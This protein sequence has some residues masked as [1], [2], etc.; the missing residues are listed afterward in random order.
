MDPVVTGSLIS[1]GSSV[2]GGLFGSKSAKR[3]N[4]RNEALQR[5]FAQHGIQWKVEDAKRAGIH[6]VA[7]LGAQGASYSPSTVVDPMGDALAQ[8]GQSIGSGVS[9][10]RVSPVEQASIR[11]ADAETDYYK[12]LT[13][14]S[15][16]ARIGQNQNHATPSVQTMP[17]AEPAASAL[18]LP[19]GK[20]VPLGPHSDAE[21]YETRYGDVAQE[22]GGLVTLGGDLVGLIPE[23]IFDEI[24]QGQ[25]D[26]AAD[27]RQRGWRKANRY[28]KATPKPYVAGVQYNSAARRRARRYEP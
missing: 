6:P 15:I 7:A 10:T 26:H 25:I 19:G 9:R 14:A 21:A 17:V 1:A 23:S 3:Q 13:R 27:I 8:A 12:E 24:V 22:V 11:K 2:L 16:Q 5:E 28:K 20:L 4:R 18:R